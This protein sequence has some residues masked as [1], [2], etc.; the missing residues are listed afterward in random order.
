MIIIRIIKIRVAMIIIIILMT[1]E[2]NYDNWDEGCESGCRIGLG[3]LV[4]VQDC[5][6]VVWCIL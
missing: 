4:Y 6:L 5:G 2:N 3:P 1:S